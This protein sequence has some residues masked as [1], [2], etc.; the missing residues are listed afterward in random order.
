MLVIFLPQ[1]GRDCATYKKWSNHE[2]NKAKA[3]DLDAVLNLFF[4]QSDPAFHE[5]KIQLI[6]EQVPVCRQPF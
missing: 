3:Y 2:P 1:T 4:V 6:I 5:L